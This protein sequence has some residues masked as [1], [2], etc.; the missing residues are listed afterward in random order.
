MSRAGAKPENN[1]SVSE[2]NQ[3]AGVSINSAARL[4][5]AGLISAFVAIA[6]GNLISQTW[7]YAL[8]VVIGSQAVLYVTFHLPAKATAAE[9]SITSLRNSTELFSVAFD[10]AAIGMALVFPNG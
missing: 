1:R 8:V 4:L 10:Y 7:L 9:S 6:A 5:F 2:A 3:L